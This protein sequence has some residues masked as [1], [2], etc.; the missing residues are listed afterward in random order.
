MKHEGGGAETI[1]VRDGEPV[2][3]VAELTYSAGEEVK[4]KVRSDVADEVHVHGYDLSKDV[5]A[6]GTVS[7]SFPAELEGI[8]EVELEERA[9]Q[10]AELRVNP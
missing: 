3:G 1:V 2:G 10:I 8:F 5:A 9:E 4:F 7:F 6:G